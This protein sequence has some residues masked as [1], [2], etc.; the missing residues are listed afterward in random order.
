MHQRDAGS[1]QHAQ[2]LQQRSW[3]VPSYALQPFK[4]LYDC[5]PSVSKCIQCLLLPCSCGC[6]SLHASLCM[7][8]QSQ[9]M[10]LMACSAASW[11]QR[12]L[13]KHSTCCTVGLLNCTPV[14]SKHDAALQPVAASAHVCPTSDHV[15]HNPA[16]VPLTLCPRPLD[17]L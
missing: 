2:L 5:A 14:H 17:P 10:C 15:S 11:K 4:K 3:Q 9:Q 16:R 7:Q 1:C 13:Y 12:M 8:T 6:V